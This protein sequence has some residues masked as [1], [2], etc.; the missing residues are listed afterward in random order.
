MQSESVVKG[1]APYNPLKV[2]HQYESEIEDLA[3]KYREHVKKKEVTPTLPYTIQGIVKN[4]LRYM[5]NL[6]TK[7]PPTSEE[8]RKLREIRRGYKNLLK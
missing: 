5:T 7:L 3:D 6:L 8:A 1:R 2:A 4:E